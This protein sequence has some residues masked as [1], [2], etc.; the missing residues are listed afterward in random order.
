MFK[1][2]DVT[3]EKDVSYIVNTLPSITFL[4]Q[5][6]DTTGEGSLQKMRIY[7]PLYW[8]WNILPTL[9]QIVLAT[10]WA[11]FGVIV[12]LQYEF[13]LQRCQPVGCQ[14]G[15][16]SKYNLFQSSTVKFWYFLANLKRLALFPLLRSGFRNCYLSSK[17]TTRRPSSDSVSANRSFSI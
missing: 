14:L 1:F 16:I 8:Y 7:Q 15:F 12:Q 5:V 13:S 3:L 17:T 10:L 9:L 11:M 4:S 2:N 6:F